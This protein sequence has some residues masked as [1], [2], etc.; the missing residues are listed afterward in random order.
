MLCTYQSISLYLLCLSSWY[1]Y[2]ISFTSIFSFVFNKLEILK[3]LELDLV[4]H[5]LDAKYVYNMNKM[6]TFLYN[7]ADR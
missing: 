4:V 6:S 2:Q 3:L 1:G 7:L 5:S